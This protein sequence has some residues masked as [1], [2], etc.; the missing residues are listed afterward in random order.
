M[1]I[2]EVQEEQFIINARDEK[3]KALEKKVY[4]DRQQEINRKVSIFGAHDI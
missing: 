4:D 1:D 2:K 3:K